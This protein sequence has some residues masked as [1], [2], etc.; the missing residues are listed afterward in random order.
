MQCKLFQIYWTAQKCNKF[1]ANTGPYDTAILMI[2]NFKSR[3]DKRAGEVA[4]RFM[5]LQTQYRS[6][7][8]RALCIE[9][10]ISLRL[11]F[12]MILAQRFTKRTESGRLESQITLN[13][14][15]CL[16]QQ[17]PFYN[18]VHQRERIR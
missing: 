17:I 10:S 6:N 2:H 15:L 12:D 7:A 14:S 16:E 11:T 8:M 5:V 18:P 4:G 9:A 13:A 1:N 3:A